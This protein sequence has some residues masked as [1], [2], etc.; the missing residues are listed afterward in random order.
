VFVPLL[1]VLAVD[2]FLVSR[3]TWNLGEN[4]PQRWAMLVP[5]VLGF[6]AYQLVN[7]GYVGWWARGWARIDGW[8]QFTPTTW[9][10][11]SL[12]SFVVAA[13]ATVPVGLLLRGSARRRKEPQC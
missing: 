8:L 2:Y 6:L 3:R 7:P 4:A 12:L 10:S 9:M 5:W 1:G 13:V 11:A